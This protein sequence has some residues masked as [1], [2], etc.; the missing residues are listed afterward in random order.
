MP[1]TVVKKSIDGSSVNFIKL[2]DVGATETHLIQRNK[3]HFVVCLSSQT[4]CNQAC[5]MCQLTATGQ[6]KY[7]NTTVEG[8]LEQARAALKYYKAHRPQFLPDKVCF[9]FMSRGEPLNNPHL[10]A[11]FRLIV[12]EL[13]HMA[14]QYGLEAKFQMATSFPKSYEGD[15]IEDIPNNVALYYS[16]YS[17]DLKFRR[18]WLSKSLL[19]EVAIS[20]LQE[21]HKETGGEVRLQY[22]FIKGENDSLGHTQEIADILTNLEFY[23]DF[24]ILKYS[25]YS[26][27]Q[28]EPSGQDVV[29]RNI[30]LLEKL[31]PVN[32]KSVKPVGTDVKSSC[33]MFFNTK[34]DL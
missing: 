1:N 24:N 23:P 11:N 19:G 8:Y 27:K 3:Q 14:Y 29:D 28:G 26:E 6:T 33:G 16:L 12:N 7:T 30:N 15:L 20:E 17:L 10:M 22:S 5:R 13:A 32:I 18:K 34:E 21:W 25:P 9:S 31:L 2:E 4:G